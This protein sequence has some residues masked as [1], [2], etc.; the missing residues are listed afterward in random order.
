MPDWPPSIHEA[1]DNAYNAPSQILQPQDA[2]VVLGNEY[3]RETPHQT[4]PNLSLSFY[5]RS[6]ESAL[7]QMQFGIDAFLDDPDPIVDPE[8][9]TNLVVDNYAHSPDFVDSYGQPGPY[10]NENR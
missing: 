4:M 2:A 3:P 6:L 9:D 5:G 1:V 10:T 7:P 8:M